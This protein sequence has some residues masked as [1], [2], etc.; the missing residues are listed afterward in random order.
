MT[1]EDVIKLVVPP[2]LLKQ[3]NVCLI[4]REAE[5]P[6]YSHTRFVILS[7]IRKNHK[8]I[9]H[10]KLSNILLTSIIGLLTFGA[11]PFEISETKN[12]TTSKRSDL[13]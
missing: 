10:L 6:S 5:H 12:L 3:E 13:N 8:T 2:N 11:P 9:T 1:K 7:S 4:P